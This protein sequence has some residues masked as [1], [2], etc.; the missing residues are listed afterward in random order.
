MK[1]DQKENISNTMRTS[2]MPTKAQIAWR[3]KFARMSK[4]G[5][6]RKKI[7]KSKTKATPRPKVPA[8]QRITKVQIKRKLK[9]VREDMKRFPDNMSL[10]VER[11]KLLWELKNWF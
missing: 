7:T 1:I 2:F 8:S 3:K 4:A 6:F 9:A 5:K 10:K 11:D